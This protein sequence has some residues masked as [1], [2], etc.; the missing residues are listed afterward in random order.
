MKKILI[1]GGAGFIG[2]NLALQLLKNG[3]FV[4][5]LDNLS[6]GNKENLTPL[7]NYY[8][9][10]E[11]IEGDIRSLSVCE[12]ACKGMDAVSHQA[13]LGSVPRS[14]INP[15]DTNEVNISGFVNILSAA[16]KAG[17][18]R[19][20]F[21]S[22]SSVYGDESSLPKQEEKIG[23]PLSPYAVTKL[24]NELYADVFGK[25]YNMELIG[26]RYFNVFGP[27][28]DPNGE[29]AAV[30][31][32]FVK[33]VLQ[34]V[35]PFIN[36]DGLQTRDFTYIDNVVQAN[37]LGLNTNNPIAINQIYNVAYGENHTILE[38]FE[39]ICRC[40]KKNIKPVFRDA[41]AGDVRD[42]L[43]DISKIKSHLGYNPE[44]SFDMGIEKTISYFKNIFGNH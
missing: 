4:R 21:A 15:I 31:P 26:F 19:V 23:K 40:L 5:V 8:D 44:Y 25:C 42:S 32:L 3:H 16:K 36:G 43:A 18:N 39:K 34:N 30:I 13:A 7:I 35:S 33:A 24:S 9:Q 20:V 11:F 1:T 28:Q 41:R 2:S 29:Y 27:G 14:I 22:S 12:L 6:T 10:F 38:I 17:I 37:I